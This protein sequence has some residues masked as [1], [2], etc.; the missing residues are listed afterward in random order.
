MIRQEWES[1]MQTCKYSTSS[2]NTDADELILT[3]KMQNFCQNW[4]K[5]INP[6]ATFPYGQYSPGKLT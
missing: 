2:D 6:T 5:S 1:K 3:L 4:E